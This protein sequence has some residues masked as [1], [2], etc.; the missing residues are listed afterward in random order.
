[1]ARFLTPAWAEAM[2]EALAGVVLPTPGP[3]AGLAAQGGTFTV[4]E[5]VRG[6]P[7]G[8]VRLL[9]SAAQGALTLALDTSDGS[10][11]VSDVTIILT[12]EDAVALSRGTLTPAEALTA[13]RIRVRGDLSVLAAAQSLMTA[14]RE[15]TRA[16][17]ASTTV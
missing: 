10:A 14:A 7:E 13:G 15:Y 6:G 3:D 11:L 4:V 16:V 2:N 17:D 12:H 5:E 1:M 9:L 8:D